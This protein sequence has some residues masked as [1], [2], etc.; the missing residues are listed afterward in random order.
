MVL[1]AKSQI[2]WMARIIFYGSELWASLRQYSNLSVNDD[3]VKV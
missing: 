2:E 1:D 3:G